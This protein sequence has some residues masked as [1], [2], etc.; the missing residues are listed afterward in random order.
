MVPSSLTLCFTHSRFKV[1]SRWIG[2]AEPGSGLCPGFP[3]A[4]KGHVGHFNS[5]P[6]DSS[7]SKVTGATSRDH[8]PGRT[9]SGTLERECGL[10]G[11]GALCCIRLGLCHSGVLAACLSSCLSVLLVSSAFGVPVA[12]FV[13]I[14][15]LSY[16][17]M[18]NI[19]PIL[20]P[21]FYQRG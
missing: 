5:F 11:G 4:K 8:Q 7:T 1:S 10:E 16:R 21:F 9:V 18:M 2:L 6:Q 20:C 12:I 19:L 17:V 14:L 13:F 3:V 15:G